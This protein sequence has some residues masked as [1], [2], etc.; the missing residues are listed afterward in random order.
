MPCFGRNMEMLNEVGTTFYL[1][2][3]PK[4]LAH[5]L[6][7]AKSSRPLIAGL[8]KEELLPFIEDKLSQREDYYKQA[9]IVLSREEQTAQHIGDITD[10]LH[11]PL[12]K[13]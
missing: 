2:R 12:Q 4:E 13:N 6:F 9:S 10:L 3:S 1:E 11:Q 5:R 8:N 7:H